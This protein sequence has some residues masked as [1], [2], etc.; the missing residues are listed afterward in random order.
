MLYL[1]IHL[2]TISMQFFKNWGI[3]VLALLMLAGIAP[4]FA[5][6][7][8][9]VETLAEDEI[10]TAVDQEQDF[11]NEDEDQISVNIVGMLIEIGSTDVPTTMIIRGNADQAAYTVNIGENT[12]L[13]QRRDQMTQL[14]DWIPGDQIRVIGAHNQNTNVIDANIV[15]NH[16]IKT[17]SN[18]G[19]NGWIEEIDTENSIV[20]VQWRGEIHRIHITDATHI[21]AGL[22]NPAEF[23]DLKIGDRVRGRLLKRSGE[24]VLEAKIL[25][26]LRRGEDLFMK[27]RTWVTR[28]QLVAI[29]DTTAPTQMQVKILR[30][31]NLRKG[32]VN[33]LVGQEGDIRTV[34]ISEDTKLKMRRGGSMS[35]EDMVVGD[36][37]LIVGRANDT[38][39]IDAKLVK[40]NTIRTVSTVGHAGTIVKI[41]EQNKNVSI[42]WN[43]GVHRVDLDGARLLSA[44]DG[45]KAVLDF[46][47]L[48]IGDRV[49]GRG[50]KNARLPV[51]DGDLLVVVKNKVY[52]FGKKLRLEKKIIKTSD[53]EVEVEV[54]IEQEDGNVQVEI[55]VE[56][57]GEAT[58]SDNGSVTTGD[59]SASVS[60][61]ST[62]GSG[63]DSTSVTT[64]VATSA[65]TGGNSI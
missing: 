38:G 9:G 5:T 40:D 28:G 7:T 17:V 21:V 50:T 55:E 44:I 18:K 41:N 47:D 65:N 10:L 46:S 32:D 1:S 27:V 4:V 11:T 51:I 22:K 60:V 53:G 25:I 61:D 49:R 13:G 26:V 52:T 42:F 29:D 20:G 15:V 63:G 2:S 58:T 8:D 48:H 57:E 56:V 24:D 14:S 37:L 33:N 23:G 59:A 39:E 64:D 45:E 30:N 6:S 36:R 43:G 54:E 19:L 35:L 16:S 12:V 31:K 34:N 62:V 3:G